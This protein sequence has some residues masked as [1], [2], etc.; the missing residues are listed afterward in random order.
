MKGDLQEIGNKMGKI[1]MKPVNKFLPIVAVSKVCNYLIPDEIL[2]FLLV[3]KDNLRKLL[4]SKLPFLIVEQATYLPETQQKILEKRV[5]SFFPDVLMVMVKKQNLHVYYIYIDEARFCPKIRE[6]MIDFRCA[7]A[8]Q[9]FKEIESEED[10]PNEM[11][12]IYREFLSV[13][14]IDHSLTA[15]QMSELIMEFFLNYPRIGCASLFACSSPNV[16]YAHVADKFCF[17]LNGNYGMI[18]M[19]RETIEVVEDSEVLILVSTPELLD[20]NLLL[21]CLIPTDGS[22]SGELH[23]NHLER[24]VCPLDFLGQGEFTLTTT[25]KCLKTKK[26]VRDFVIRQCKD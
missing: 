17:R 1:Q 26:M 12:Q 23:F 10:T 19:F 24:A 11:K 16:A 6:E 9:I 15:M 2:E 5:P 22:V 13:A 7:K 4:R 21:F 8:W 14:T 25:V 20:G 18:Q 3:S